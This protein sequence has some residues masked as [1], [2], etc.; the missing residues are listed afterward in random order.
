LLDETEEWPFS[1]NNICA[2]LGISPSYLRRH[3]LRWK[4]GHLCR[5]EHS[6]AGMK[7]CRSA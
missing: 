7:L 2:G 1:F 5:G 4:A 3:V 6:R